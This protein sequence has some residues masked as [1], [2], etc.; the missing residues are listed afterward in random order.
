MQESPSVTTILLAAGE[1]KRMKS[2]N[3]TPK[4]LHKL[5]GTP[6]LERVIHAAKGCCYISNLCLIL[7]E[8]IAPFKSTLEKFPEISVCLQK[9]KNGM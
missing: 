2:K 1:G 8:D 7:G 6:M 3:K 9:K 4:V 5:R